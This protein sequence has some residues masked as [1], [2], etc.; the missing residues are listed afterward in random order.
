[1]AAQKRMSPVC[2]KLRARSAMRHVRRAGARCER[3]QGAPAAVRQL[4]EELRGA[5]AVVGVD[6]GDLRA[7]ASAART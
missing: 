2:R 7:G 3:E 4:E 6:G 1:M 5:G